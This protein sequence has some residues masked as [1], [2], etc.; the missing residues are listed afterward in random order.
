[1]G[2][3]E[4]KIT[5]Q[6]KAKAAISRGSRGLA[7]VIL[8]DATKDQ[9][10]TP[11]TRWQEVSADDW[12]EESLKTLKLVCAGS[13]QR[14][15]VVRLLKQEDAADLQGTLDAIWP[16]NMDYLAYPG[17]TA[18][19]KTVIKDWIQ[20]NQENGKKVKVVLP[21]CDADDMHIINFSTGNITAKWED[22]EETV[23]YTGAEYCCRIAGI[24]AGLPLTQSCTYY[25]LPEVVDAELATDPDAEI[26][27]GRLII[28]YDGEKYKLGRG[29]TSLTTVTETEPEDCKKIKIVEGMD[30]IRYDI[31]ST[32]EGTYVGK[33]ANIYDNKQIFVGLVNDYF[34]QLYGSVLDGNEEN[35]VQVSAEGNRKYLEEKGI[36]TSEMTDQQLLEA[37]TGSW[38][39][40]EGKC[41]LLDA[42]EDLDLT[43]NM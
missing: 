32:F 25:E 37:N 35:Y 5:F 9:F 13:P 17:Y 31:Y 34:R 16:L 22:E 26:D 8:D 29:V 10:L 36:D 6:R 23:E 12:S 41:R 42:M 43:M 1:M 28:V 4:I 14:V 21:A 18:A 38:V 7:A 2:L 40:L 33:V 11:Y 20:M 19:D 15:V 30:V 27:A 24:L 39:F 3:P